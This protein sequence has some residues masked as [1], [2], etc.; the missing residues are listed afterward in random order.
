MFPTK[1][2]N[3]AISVTP[4]ENGHYLCRLTLTLQGRTREPQSFQG[5]SPN[6]AIAI[7]LEDLARE[8][9]LQS[10]AEQNLAWDAV[11]RSLSG[12]VMEKRFHVVLHYERVVSEESKFEAMHRTLLGNT[13]IENAEISIIRVDPELP[14]APWKG[15]RE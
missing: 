4:G 15:R 11:E 2:D 13:V 8:L 14:I 3:I 5:Q 12:D 10:E 7:A 6:H 1:S 9:R